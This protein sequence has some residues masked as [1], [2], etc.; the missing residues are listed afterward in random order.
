MAYNFDENH[1]CDICGI[2]PQE[3]EEKQIGA[4]I[5]RGQYG[6]SKFETSFQ[7]GFDGSVHCMRCH[8]EKSLKELFDLMDKKRVPPEPKTKTGKVKR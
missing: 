5:T 4:M 1:K 7:L 3:A 6:Y 2:T 8:K